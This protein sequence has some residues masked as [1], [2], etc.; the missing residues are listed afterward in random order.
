[1]STVSYRRAVAADVPALARFG[2]ASFA[3][4]FGHNYPAAELAAY[5]A[6]A[7][8]PAK[9][10]R[11]V[12]DPACLTELAVGPDGTILGYAYSGPLDLP[13]PDPEPGAYELKRLY[14]DPV[15]QGQGAAGQ[16]WQGCLSAAQAAWAP[17][18]Y[19]GVWSAND[20]ALSFY[21]RLGFTEVGTYHFQ[22]GAVI[23]VELIL[24]LGLED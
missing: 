17:A 18:I 16:L 1:M 15:L 6:R 2:A 12:G 4:T 19:L 8:D 22:V 10:A 3:H 21:R 11:E 24:R 7:Y 20:R 23:D 14:L 5:L 13:L 9:V